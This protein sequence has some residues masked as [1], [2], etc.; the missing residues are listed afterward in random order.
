MAL[1]Q[2]G[3]LYVTAGF[4]FPK[5][6]VETAKKY[7][8]GI[9][10]MSPEGELLKFI[11]VPI[12]MITNCTFGDNDLKTLYITAGHKLWSIRTSTPGYLAWPPAK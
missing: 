6:P 10:V 12:D 5:P 1:D 2:K 11:Q 3:R 4:N 7:K 8:A 9:Y